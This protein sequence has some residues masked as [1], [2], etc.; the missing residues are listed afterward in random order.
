MPSTTNG[1]SKPAFQVAPFPLQ[2]RGGH[3]P[4]MGLAW[5][6]A[7]S[8]GLSEEQS[9]CQELGHLGGPVVP[10]LF[11]LSHH[12]GTLE[13]RDSQPRSLPGTEQG[14]RTGPSFPWPRTGEICNTSLSKVSYERW[15]G[16]A[17]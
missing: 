9:W 11:A 12:V 16:L 8:Q 5:L 1:D 13:R 17:A 4:G 10:T 15:A 14:L 6:P 7:L 3:Q 2:A